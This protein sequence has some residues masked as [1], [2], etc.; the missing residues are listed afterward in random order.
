MAALEQPETVR[1]TDPTADVTAS[2]QGDFDTGW[3]AYERGNYET[4]HA[5]WRPL[6]EQGDIIAQYNIASMYDNGRGVAEDKSEA[7]RWYRAAA[8]Q[9]DVD[10]QF[11]LG[12]MYDSGEGVDMEAVK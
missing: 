12:F 9:G 1:N 6:A 4:A 8:K 5:A 10:A 3:Q 7:A 11:S 2:A